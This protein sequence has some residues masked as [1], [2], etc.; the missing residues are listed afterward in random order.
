MTSMARADMVLAPP[1][2]LPPSTRS[3]DIGEAFFLLLS[4]TQ[5]R[6]VYE[7]LWERCRR[8]S[9]GVATAGRA[10]RRFTV[11]L[12][13]SRLGRG[14]QERCKPPAASS[15]SQVVPKLHQVFRK[16]P[17]TIH[18]SRNRVCGS[19]VRRCAKIRS[20]RMACTWRRSAADG[21][22]IPEAS[23]EVVQGEGV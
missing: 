19:N 12:S 8:R 15:A 10:T 20:L 14:R 17:H 13:P 4:H 7:G 1:P 9:H 5:T 16:P 18:C 21:E 2:L 23:R 11:Q 3:A 22:G 6:L